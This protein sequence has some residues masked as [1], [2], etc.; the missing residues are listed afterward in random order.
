MDALTFHSQSLQT[1][2]CV[3]AELS[4]TCACGRAAPAG[5]SHT[6]CIPQAFF[7]SPAVVSFG[8]NKHQNPTPRARGKQWKSLLESNRRLPFGALAD[9]DPLSL[10]SGLRLADS[11]YCH[12]TDG[13]SEKTDGCSLPGQ[14]PVLLSQDTCQG[15][16]CPK[17]PGC[18]LS[19]EMDALWGRGGRKPSVPPLRVFSDPGGPRAA[20]PL[21]LKA[22]TSHLSVLQ[23]K[24][25][26]IYKP[27]LWL[28]LPYSLH[29]TLNMVP[30]SSNI[31]AA[32]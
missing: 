22:P 17:P 13:E 25:K 21:L 14:P 24:K 23:K 32:F 5:C 29:E 7:L 18:D 28:M 27:S 31:T 1:C 30:V 16:G 4:V 26:S 11:C 2:G 12:H 8:W 9:A 19:P 20:E 15:L 3:L 6:A 10:S